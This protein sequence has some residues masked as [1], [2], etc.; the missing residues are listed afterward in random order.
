MVCIDIVEEISIESRKW[1]RQPRF[2]RA[3]WC[4]GWIKAH[5]KADR[6]RSVSSRDA[7]E[8]L[9]KWLSLEKGDDAVSES[10]MKVALNETNVFGMPLLGF[11][12]IALPGVSFGLAEQGFARARE[13]CE[14]MR[15]AS[16]AM[17]EALRET[18]SSNARSTTDYGLKV[19]EISNANAASAI[20]FF[21]HLLG[22]KSVADVYTLSASQARKTFDIA[23]DQNKELW[24]IAQKLATETG[25]PIRDHFAKVLHKAS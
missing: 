10:E 21:V 11:P 8:R 1:N 12:K 19:L 17:T 9:G 24:A 2:R 13:G 5:P 14:K 18:Y 16:E 23:S 22:S 7:S 20:D 25:E 15:V 3:Q 6:T 4:R